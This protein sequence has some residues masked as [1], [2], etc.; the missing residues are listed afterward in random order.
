MPFGLLPLTKRP[1]LIH[2]L[3]MTA[4]FEFKSNGNHPYTGIFKGADNGILRFSL[5]A[6]PDDN[7][8]IPAFAFKFFRD[9]MESANLFTMYGLTGQQ[10]DSNV[11]AHDMTSHI[12]MINSKAPTA[13]KLLSKSF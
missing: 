4:E 2:S 9:G 5:A 6:K 1:K 7:V 8:I 13:L 11:F 10:N 3:G 12:P